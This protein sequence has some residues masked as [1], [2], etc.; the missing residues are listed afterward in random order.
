MLGNANLVCN[1]VVQLPELLRPAEAKDP[2]DHLALAVE[3]HGVGQAPI[4][5]ELLHA[6]APYQDRERRPVRS[7]ERQHAP[8]VHIVRHPAISKSLRSNS[9]YNSAMWGNSSRQGSHHDAQ[10]FTSVT[11]PANRA[12]VTVSPARLGSANPGPNWSRL[13]GATRSA[14]ASSESASNRAS[15]PLASTAT[16]VSR[17][18]RCRVAR[19]APVAGSSTSTRSRVAAE[20]S[21]PRAYSRPSGGGPS[22]SATLTSAALSRSSAPLAGRNSGSR[23]PGSSPRLAVQ[24]SWPPGPYFWISSRTSGA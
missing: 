12:S 19:I 22:A 17:G 20:S 14:P 13:A 24:A 3:Q 16:A 6:A 8:R 11:L 10:K 7:H 4:V 15:A 21:E 23:S 18:P 5:I 2:L 1:S 9:R